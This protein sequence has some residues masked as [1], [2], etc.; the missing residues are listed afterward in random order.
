MSA[1]TSCSFTKTAVVPA[2]SGAYG[3]ARVQKRQE[4]ER[5]ACG[6]ECHS[7]GLQ[8][9]GQRRDDSGEGGFILDRPPTEIGFL[10]SD[11]LKG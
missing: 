6:A 10:F 8:R 9:D 5:R 7:R 11:L 1:A 2:L 3:K 4:P